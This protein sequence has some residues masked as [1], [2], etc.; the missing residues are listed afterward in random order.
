LV[1]PTPAP[2]G[3]D[4]RSWPMLGVLSLSVLAG[5]SVWFAQSAVAPELQLRWGWSAAQVGWLTS[6]VQVGFVAGT[7]LAAILN[8]ADILPSRRYFALSALLAAGANLLLVVLPGWEAA[9]VTR[10]LT[11]FF[12]AGVYPPAMKMAAT[13][14][15][16][17][18]GLAIGT[19]V[20]AL[21][22]GKAIPYLVHALGG[23]DPG[24]V[25]GSTSVAAVGAAL[26]ILVAYR[27]GPNPFERRPFRWALAREVFR[28]REWRLVTAG[29]CG[30]MLEL[31]SYWTW[32]AAYLAASQVVGEPSLLAFVAI[33]LGGAG[34][35][36][37]GA[38][39]DRIG[40]ERLV[41]RAM[42]VSGGCALLVGFV[43]QIPWLLVGVAMIWGVAVIMDSAQ[44][45]ALVTERVPSYAVGTALTL[46]T[47]LGFAVTVAT[48]QLVPTLAEAFG[49][50]WS[51]AI[52][53]LGPALGIAAIR[54]LGRGTGMAQTPETSGGSA[55]PDR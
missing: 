18:R 37:G 23:A 13:W 52:L 30:H 5:M 22:V 26:L 32:L 39:A 29:Y 10:F 34:C 45:S 11:G 14:F 8:L 15:V 24:L 33:A 38:V 16:S 2:E 35:I 6:A 20:G 43:F 25:V 55:I 7:L 19:V 1:T 31:Y 17:A 50:R 46:Q 53:A 28:I 21:T 4:P 36:W 49:W 3:R 51:F 47:S 54:R 42:A 27:D 40:R 9:L 44:F 41:N 48:V 12:L